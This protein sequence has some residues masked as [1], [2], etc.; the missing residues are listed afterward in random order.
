MV[1]ATDIKEPKREVIKPELKEL[2][3]SVAKKD[4]PACCVCKKQISR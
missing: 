1:C 4:Y 3:E 2:Q